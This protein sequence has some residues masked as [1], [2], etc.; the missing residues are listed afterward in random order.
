V[1]TPTSGASSRIISEAPAVPDD[2]ACF[3][4]SGRVA[5]LPDQPVPRNRLSR[6]KP[7]RYLLSCSF[8]LLILLAGAASAQ[9]PDYA[10]A[11]RLLS[12]NIDPLVY[13]VPDSPAWR[14]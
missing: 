4:K 1:S 9:T 12:W 6:T 11:E 14:T 8:A 7:L 13:G 3:R 5:Y 2:R 10:R